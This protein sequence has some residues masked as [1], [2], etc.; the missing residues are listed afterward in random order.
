VSNLTIFEPARRWGTVFQ[1]AAITLLLSASAWGIWQAA[2]AEIGPVFILYTLPAFISVILVPLLVYRLYALWSAYYHIERD[3]MRLRWGFRIED[4]PIGSVLWISRAADLEQRLPLPWL[5]WPG[6][7]IGTRHLPDGSHL[8]F[9]AG[10]AG[11]LIVIATQKQY[12]AISPHRA[13]LFLETF[14]RLMEIGSLSPIPPRSIYPSFLLARVWRKKSARNLLLTGFALNIALL[15]LVSVE[16][17]QVN[18]VYLGF[19]SASEPVP[20]VRLLLLPFISSAFFLINAFLGVFFYRG[21]VELPPIDEDLPRRIDIN[22]DPAR[23]SASGDHSPDRWW[24]KYNQVLTELQ[25]ELSLV[26]G[27][28]LAYLLWWSGA[29]TPALFTLAIVY[30]IRSAG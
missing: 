12:Y 4:I 24:L 9:M 16:I 26:P 3:G 14:Q 5:L 22:I 7:V 15:A 10:S 1:A 23:L 8:E 30:L 6:S 29:I 25:Q 13:D 28:Y 19:A 17:P 21:A 2:R 20:A 27:K 11:E 18:S